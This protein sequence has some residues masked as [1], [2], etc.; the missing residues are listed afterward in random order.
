MQNRKSST[1]TQNIRGRG[2]RGNTGSRLRPP[3][4]SVDRLATD[5]GNILSVSRSSGLDRGG[6]ALKSFETQEAYRKFIQEKILEYWKQYQS[7]EHLSEADMKQKTEVEGNIMIL[8]RKLREGIA[9]TERKDSFSLEVYETSLYL[10]VIFSLPGQTNAITSHLIPSFSVYT[11]ADFLSD[12][13]VLVS[14]V[15]ALVVSH[16][17]QQLYLDRLKSVPIPH[18]L[19][20]HANSWVEAVTRCLRRQEYRGLDGLTRSSAVDILVSSLSAAPRHSQDSGSSSVPVDA[21]VPMQQNLVRLAINTLI[22]RLREK[23]RIVAWRIF[24]SAYREFKLPVLDTRAWLATGL[25]LG[26]D[27]SGDDSVD[28]WLSQAASSGEVER[29]VGAEGQWAIK[30]RR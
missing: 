1:S 27:K 11:P 21:F 22:D 28:S 4:D 29:K 12:A 5:F 7:G 10:S 25:L 9:S 3:N 13:C 15:D 18:L 17:S 14:L 2:K 6:D 26:S 23:A 19:H 24:R 30:K 8:F 20:G 16:P